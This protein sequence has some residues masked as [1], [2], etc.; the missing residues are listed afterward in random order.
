MS[1]KSILRS[2]RLNR[3]SSLKRYL[4]KSDAWCYGYNEN[5]MPQLIPNDI[6]QKTSV[7]VISAFPDPLSVFPR[8]DVNHRR[9]AVAFSHERAVSVG[10]SILV[11]LAGVSPSVAGATIFD[12]LHFR[13]DIEVDDSTV[14][15]GDWPGPDFVDSGRPSHSVVSVSST[16]I[17]TMSPQLFA[18]RVWFAWVIASLR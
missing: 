15:F 7:R 4:H 17:C 9:S 11:D 6:P 3:P 10:L 8:S 16:N 5:I 18:F 1:A 13:T 12:F 2:T 14:E